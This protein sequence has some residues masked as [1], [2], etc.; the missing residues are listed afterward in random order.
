MGK[1]NGVNITKL[2]ADTVQNQFSGHIVFR[3]GNSE[4]KLFFEN[5]YLT[6]SSSNDPSDYLG[7]YLINE[8]II[9]LEQFNRAYK[10]ELETDVKMGAILNLIGLAPVDKISESL[11]NKIVDT[12]F[13]VSCWGSGEYELSEDY[14]LTANTVDIRFS[15]DDLTRHLNIRGSEFSDIIQMFGVLGEV[16]ETSILD[17]DVSRLKKLDQQIVNLLSIGKTLP[18]TLRA[19]P[20]HFYLI[21]RHMHKLFEQGILLPGKGHS[22]SEHQIYENLL[23]ISGN[24]KPQEIEEITREEVGDIFRLAEQA[25][26]DKNYWKAALY[27][28]VLLNINPN[29]IVFRDSLNNAEYQYTLYFYRKVLAPAATVRHSEGVGVIS[30][31]FEEKVH[32]LLAKHPLKIR[33]IVN[34]FSDHYPEV[35]ILNSIERLKSKG[36]IVEVS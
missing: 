10:T 1:L 30:D 9:N 22:L 2:I 21:A 27:Y 17:K 36:Y 26:A 19:L 4:K 6:G 5:R 29:N 23:S 32:L 25:S 31:P 11:T 7:Q 24:K 12:T 35:K 16:P 13:I 20:V 33:E 15:L 8:G 28:R 3:N 14:P 34:Y 18:E